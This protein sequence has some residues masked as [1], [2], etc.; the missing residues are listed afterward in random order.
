[1]SIRDAAAAAQARDLHDLVATVMD[2]ALRLQSLVTNIVHGTDVG[3]VH[4]I[5]DNLRWTEEQAKELVLEAVDVM[6]EAKRMR[7]RFPW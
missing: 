7:Q 3:A 4:V 6:H 2:R 5:E 1:M